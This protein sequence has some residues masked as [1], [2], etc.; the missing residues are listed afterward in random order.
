MF[1]YLGACLTR[2]MSNKVSYDDITAYLTTLGVSAKDIKACPQTKPALN[3]L[4]AMHGGDLSRLAEVR[5]AGAEAVAV[6]KQNAMARWRLRPLKE[7]ETSR[8]SCG[9]NPA[10][11]PISRSPVRSLPLL[12]RPLLT[13]GSSPTVVAAPRLRPLRC[14]R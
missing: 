9:S 13:L 3:A 11:P 14:G 6:A 5:A 2:S 10:L 12:P 8:V 1:G 7:H 4:A